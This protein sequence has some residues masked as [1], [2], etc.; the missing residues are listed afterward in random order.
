MMFEFS[1]NGYYIFNNRPYLVTQGLL[2]FLFYRIITELKIRV[3]LYSCIHIMIIR[4]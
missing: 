4:G 3:R 2:Y 1:L